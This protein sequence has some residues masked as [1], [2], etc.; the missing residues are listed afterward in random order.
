MNLII[1]E[2]APNTLIGNTIVVTGAFLILI[3]LIRIF[4]W[5]RIILIFETR[6]KKISDDIDSAEKLRKSADELVQKREL[7]FSD[8]KNEAAKIIQLA[9]ETA[10]QERE[11]ILKQAKMEA[12]NVK[13]QAI[14]DIER[15][16]KEVLSEV[17]A[18][19]ADISV[20]IA[21]KLISKSLDVKS[22]SDIIDEYLSKL[23]E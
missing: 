3:I 5:K 15:E 12:I 8:A 1:A 7:E 21:E 18:D 9:N 22:Q 19:I 17:R 2:A 10:N 6:A 20:Q 4:I 13:A 14:S 23:G 16:R 11:K